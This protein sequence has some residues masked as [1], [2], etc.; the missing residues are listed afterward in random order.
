[1]SF[2]GICFVVIL[3]VALI[4]QSNIL[5]VIAIAVPILIIIGVLVSRWS[6]KYDLEKEEKEKQYRSTHYNIQ[7]YFK[8]G[9]TERPA[10]T[11]D[12]FDYDYDIRAV[13]YYYCRYSNTATCMNCSRRREHK[14]D[15]KYYYGVSDACKKYNSSDD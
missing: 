6:K 4:G 11:G 5:T 7:S 15:N 1:M 8:E 12:H 9:S 13:D 14:I 10:V 3:I 2:L